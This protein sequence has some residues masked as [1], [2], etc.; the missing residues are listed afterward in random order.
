MDFSVARNKELG[1]KYGPKNLFFVDYDYDDWYE[2]G[3]KE[4]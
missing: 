2:E 3:G 4:Q 1:P